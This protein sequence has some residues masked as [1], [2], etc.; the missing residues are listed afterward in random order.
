MTVEVTGIKAAQAAL[1]NALRDINIESELLLSIILEGIDRHTGPYIPVGKTSNLFNQRYRT[2]QMTPSGPIGELGF[3]APY[4]VYVHEGPQKNWQK[5]G[6]SN[7][8]LELGVRDYIQ[9]DLET[10]VARFQP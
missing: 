2:T 7:R 1:D 6:A 4:A 10:D 3:R 5:P 8:F 9:E